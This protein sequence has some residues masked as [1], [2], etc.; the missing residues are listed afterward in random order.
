MRNASVGDIY[1]E[2]ENQLIVN[3]GFS[4]P[5]LDWGRRK[6]RIMTAE[7][8]QK[9]VEYSVNQD[10]LNFDEQVL[11]QVRQFEMLKDAVEITRMADEI[12]QRRYLVSKNRYLIGKIAITDLNIALQEKDDATRRYTQALEDFWMAYY[13]VRLYTMYDFE[14][15]QPL[16]T[17]E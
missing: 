15:K 5:I 14:K 2:P 11:T 9:L 3:M 1:Q 6:S 4:I 17:E 10:M 16:K 13:S 12:A 7:A 8:N